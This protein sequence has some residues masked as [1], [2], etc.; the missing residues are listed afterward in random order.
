MLFLISGAAS[1]AGWVVVRFPG[2]TPRTARGVTVWLALAIVCF[3][4][5]PFAVMG[6]G[7]VLGALFAAMFV[8]LPAAICIFLSVA[9]LLLYVM[10]GISPY[11]R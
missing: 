8:A 9:W 3:L 4:G 10:R 7:T 11:G 1:L 2:L 5:T 6:V